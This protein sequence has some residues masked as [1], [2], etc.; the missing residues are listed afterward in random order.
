MRKKIAICLILFSIL[1]MSGCGNKYEGPLSCISYTGADGT[2][3][4]MDMTEEVHRQILSALNR[5]IC[6]FDKAL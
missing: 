4:L 1:G 6:H 2:V 5:G 3:S